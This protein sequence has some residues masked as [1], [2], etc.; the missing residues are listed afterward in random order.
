MKEKFYA[1]YE[2]AKLAEGKMHSVIVR[3]NMVLLAKVGGEV[4]AVS[5]RC[6]HLACQLHG[7]ILSD[8]IVMCPCHG[9]KFDIRNG[10]NTENPLTAL[11]SYK[12]KVENGKIM[13]EIKQ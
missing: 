11:K 4:Y 2:N 12:C 1:C 8:Y 5:N 9:W 13:V 6:P 3:G 10:Q 7:G